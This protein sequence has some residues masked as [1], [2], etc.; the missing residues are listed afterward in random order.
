MN[1]LRLQLHP[2]LSPKKVRNPTNTHF[3]ALVLSTLAANGSDMVNASSM[4]LC[5][6][7][8]AHTYHGTQATVN[9]DCRLNGLRDQLAIRP[10][11]MTFWEDPSWLLL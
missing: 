2:T 9:P 11:D 3:S 1:H 8:P 10:I 4:E 7:I 5:L 6:Q